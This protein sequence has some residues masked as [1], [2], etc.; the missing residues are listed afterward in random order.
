MGTDN[1]T[2]NILYP[3]TLLTAS[4]GVFAKLDRNSNSLMYQIQALLPRNL[5]GGVARLAVPVPKG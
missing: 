2:H 3:A 1:D 4:S 5:V